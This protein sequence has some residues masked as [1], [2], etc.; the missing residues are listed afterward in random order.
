[1]KKIIVAALSVLTLIVPLTASAQGRGE[2]RDRS[3]ER[4]AERNYDRPR[5]PEYRGRSAPRPERR[6]YGPPGRAL[7]PGQVLPQPYR[8][9]QIRDFN[10]HR[11]R[12][13]PVGYDWVGVGPDIY[14]MQ[15]STG[16][17]LEAIPGGY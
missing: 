1:M 17:V 7:G 10:R 12:P 16:M 14:L 8:G 11:L 3:A 4:R 15:R 6:G 5:P 13:P 9:A 2:G